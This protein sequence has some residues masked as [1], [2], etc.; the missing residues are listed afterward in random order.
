MLSKFDDDTKLGGAVASLKGREA[1]KRHQHTKVK[2]WDIT[3][4]VKFNKG[5][6]R[7]L[8]LGW[9]N[10]GCVYRLGNRRLESSTVERDLGVLVDGKLNMSQQC[11][12]RL[13]GQPCPGGASGTASPARQ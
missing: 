4:H 1:L 11:P 13:E 6:C 8:Q 9:D 2:R 3:N 12:G 7:I 10:P 5:K